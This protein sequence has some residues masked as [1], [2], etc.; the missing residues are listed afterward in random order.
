MDFKQ[1]KNEDKDV[2]ICKELSIIKHDTLGSQY[3]YVT[4]CQVHDSGDSKIPKS[5]TKNTSL[6]SSL[7]S[8]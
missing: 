5:S 4:Y 1:G 7:T 8:K 3:K 2:D 6:V